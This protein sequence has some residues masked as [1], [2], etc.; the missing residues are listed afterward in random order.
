MKLF[1]GSTSGFYGH[2]IP[3]PP[4]MDD[5]HAATA[6]SVLEG[7]GKQFK[8]D[9]KEVQRAFEKRFNITGAFK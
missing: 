8:T 6:T 5:A 7:T 3:M 4:P 9:P 2:E 1:G